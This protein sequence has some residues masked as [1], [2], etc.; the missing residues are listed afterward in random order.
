MHQKTRRKIW[1]ILATFLAIFLLAPF[2]LAKSG[3]KGTVQLIGFCVANGKVFSASK[4]RCQMKK[5]IFFKN[6]KEAFDACDPLGWCLSGNTVTHV[7]KSA[8]VRKKG[9]FFINKALA[10]KEARA[11]AAKRQHGVKKNLAPGA[12]LTDRGNIA[13]KPAPEPFLLVEQIFLKNG[14][15]HLK[16]KNQGKGRLGRQL[17]L[18]GRLIIRVGS[19]AKT[20]SLSRINSLAGLSPGQAVTFDSG[21]KIKKTTQVQVSFVHV[22]GRGKG[23]V[24][25]PPEFAKIQTNKPLGEKKKSVL[26]PKPTVIGGKVRP[27]GQRPKPVPKFLDLGIKI[28]SPTS[29]AKFYAGETI[30]IRYQVTD[31]DYRGN[32]IFVVADSRRREAARVTVPQG[33]NQVAMTLRNDVTGNEFYVEAFGSDVVY[34]ESDPFE[35]HPNS[36]RVEFLDMEHKVAHPGGRMLVRYRVSRRIAPGTITFELHSLEHR[37]GE[38]LATTT[39]SYRP[40]LPEGGLSQ[41]YETVTL[42]VPSG[43]PDGDRY[44]L[45]ALI[46]EHGERGISISHP[47]AIRAFGEGHGEEGVISI[48]PVDIIREDG[49]FLAKTV[50]AKINVQGTDAPLSNVKIQVEWWKAN[51]HPDSSVHSSIIDATLQPGLNEVVLETLGVPGLMSGLTDEAARDLICGRRYKVTVDPDHDFGSHPEWQY[52]KT[53]YY[54]DS[55]FRVRVILTRSYPGYERNSRELVDTG[56]NNPG[57]WHSMRIS[58]YPPYRY[59]SADYSLTIYIENYGCESLHASRPFTITKSWTQTAGDRRRGGRLGEY[60]T[61]TRNACEHESTTSANGN[62]RLVITCNITMDYRRNDAKITITPYDS[63]LARYLGGP[64]EIRIDFQPPD[65]NRGW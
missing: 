18:K 55:Q 22:P 21:I 41:A 39:A 25:K 58:S 2:A 65:F 63:L 46:G 45:K 3:E 12:T 29:R 14:T 24:L 54:Y 11:L 44:F 23:T 17:Q 59:H 49:P 30:H 28:L 15:I 27:N 51:H 53:I 47:F 7:R 34:G 64:M 37:D 33:N 13:R 32:I 52:E 36:A 57:A 19:K 35:I 60:E 56:I 8:C 5:G 50:K 43:I 4:S 20:W 1:S 61:V 40:P 38:P 31:R 62:R 10:D 48:Q 42:D 9:R 16:L 6:R 26:I